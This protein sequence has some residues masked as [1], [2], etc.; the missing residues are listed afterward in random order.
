MLPKPP[1]GI[2][3]SSA[4]TGSFVHKDFE[5]AAALANAFPV[6]GYLDPIR[7]TPHDLHGNLLAKTYDLAQKAAKE[8]GQA[9][10]NILY[11]SHRAGKTSVFHSLLDMFPENERLLLDCASGTSK[12]DFNGFR[13]K[14]E[15][16]QA[17][18]G[19][20]KLSLILVDEINLIKNPEERKK[21]LEFLTKQGCCTFI[22]VLSPHEEVVDEIARFAKQAGII[23]NRI[24]IVSDEADWIMEGRVNHWLKRLFNEKGIS[25]VAA[26]DFLSH[27][28][29]FDRI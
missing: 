4:M 9:S 12:F 25:V 3:Q 5:T 22:T 8:S 24:N 23:S 17:R 16:D 7:F 6:I 28:R 15:H 1:D 29:W 21:I 11:G 27:L 10:I 20:D 19:K 26:N 2:E 18:L 13:L 14:F